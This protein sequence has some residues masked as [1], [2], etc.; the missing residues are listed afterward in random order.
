MSQRNG[1]IQKKVLLLLLGGIALGLSGSPRRYFQILNAVAKEWSAIDKRVLK[2]AIA[3]L[4]KSKLISGKSNGDGTYTLLLTDHG[5]EKALTYN[6]ETMTI[7]KP[8]QWDKKWRIVIFDIPE[9]L[10]KNRDALRIHLQGLDF[11]DLQK[12]VLVHPYDCRNE[13]EYLIEWYDLR[14]F[15]RFII[16]DS[17]DNELDVAEHFRIK[18]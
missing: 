16:A 18:K 9:R 8:N 6:L 14:E 15:V 5:R 10:R 7:R 12:S 2:R 13:V 1:A 11:F 17:I 3:S 4:Y